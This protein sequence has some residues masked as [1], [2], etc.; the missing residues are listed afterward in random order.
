M[1][2]IALVITTAAGGGARL[3]APFL[4][5]AIQRLAAAC[6]QEVREVRADE[7]E[8]ALES[9][10]IDEA[11]LMLDGSMPLLTEGDCRLLMEAVEEGASSAV[12]KG[13]KTGF[14]CCQTKDGKNG[15]AM[16]VP[17]GKRALFT[18]REPR[19]L[20]TALRVL[21]RR[22]NKALMHSGVILLDPRQTYIDP[23]VRIGPGTVVHPGN[24]ITGKTVIGSHCT[25]LPNNRIQ[26]STI[27][28]STTVE[29]SVL[30]ECGVGDKSTVGPFAYLRPGAKIGDGCRIGDFVE[31][32]NS[33][34]GDGTKVSHLTYVG[35]SDLGRRINLGCGVVFV[36]YDGKKKHRTTVA[37][38]AF[39][40]CN[41][42]LVSPIQV[43]EG[44]YIAAG[45]TVTEDVP[46]GALA[47]GRARQTIKEGWVAQ[48][49]RAGKL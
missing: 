38:D 25:I 42:N 7:T 28:D 10:G 49:K 4:L 40:G 16:E 21:R 13:A 26:A 45:T 14:P 19:D 48:R 18:V 35:D 12:A 8:A 37:D 39:I 5:P 23:D 24:T 29:S 3:D 34:I 22:K 11:L 30:I 47:V 33:T 27:G 6:C 1:K 36:N 20:A 2:Y 44:A 46:V 31:I 15:D 32:K 43:G 9:L 17:L 41:V